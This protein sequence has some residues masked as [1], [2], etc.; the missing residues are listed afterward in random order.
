MEQDKEQLPEWAY[1]SGTRGI[2]G[3]LKEQIEDF[4]VEEIAD[5][6]IGDGDHLIFRLTKHNMTTLEAIRELS[7]IL[8][9]SRKRFGYAGNKDKRAVTTQYMSVEDVDPDDLE[10]VFLPDLDIQVLGYGDRIHLGKLDQ[11]DFTITIRDVNLPEDVVNERVE[12]IIDELD[13]WFPNYFGKQRF[14]S[15][16][17][18]T[19]QVGRLIL[20]GNYEEAV[21]TYIAKPYE[22]EHESVKKVREDLWE[23]RDPERGAEKFPEQYRYEKILLYHLANNEEDYKGAIKRLPEG[24]QQLFIH[25]YQSYIF[26]RALSHLIKDGFDDT[27]A[28]LPLVGYKTNLK[29]EK[30]DQKIR[31]VLDE[32]EI[33]L[34]DFKLR[35]LE[36]LRMEGDYRDCFKPVEGFELKE[37]GSDDLNI[38]KNM[39]KVSFSLQK[40]T[41]ATVF[42]R[43]IMKS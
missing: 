5:H 36:H 43:E 38:N 31:D 29:D 16:R 42:L 3:T 35:D 2:G 15:V 18:I 13:G 8:H 22:E 20:E 4:Q 37:V 32:E 26:N 30:G 27:G 6:D 17:P 14:G 39:A 25:A 28:E 12:N 41:Y 10:R 23:T 34:D 40:G 24:L 7:N 33:S 9:V 11:N 21:W 1:S 19:H